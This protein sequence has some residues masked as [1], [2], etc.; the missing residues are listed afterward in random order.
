MRLRSIAAL[1]ALAPL[2]CNGDDGGRVRDDSSVATSSTG[3]S[4]DSS[5]SETQDVASGST[6][7]GD[8]TPGDTTV[9]ADSSAGDSTGD[10]TGSESD[11]TDT[12]DTDDTT[13][14]VPGQWL[15]TIDDTAD[16]PELV[17]IDG[18]TG[19]GEAICVLPGASS[20]N[21]L[22]L[23]RDGTLY[24]HNV[25]LSRIER[26]DPCDCGFQIVGPTSVGPLHIALGPGDDLLGIEAT[27]DATYRVDV[28]TGLAHAIGPLGLDFG[29]SAVTWSDALGGPYAVDDSTSQLYS[30][31]LQTGSATLVATLSQAVATPGLA[32]RAAD[33]VLYLCED[34]TLY[35]LSPA[36]GLLTE[37][38]PIGLAGACTSL[39]APYVA[40]PCLE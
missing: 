19:V 24:V 17:R 12:D 10:A 40:E 33:D 4:E 6:A 27:L 2:S 26:V 28:Q 21:S 38:G 34:D 1:A 20:F 35:E 31:D 15:L 32:H 29:G 18:T 37:I 14:T 9:A 5:N 39:T 7:A 23:T 3:A 16:P 11:A 13:D 30:L 8:T 22:A 25:T 36:S